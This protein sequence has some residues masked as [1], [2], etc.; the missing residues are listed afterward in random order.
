MKGITPE[1]MAQIKAERK[2]RAAQ[3]AKVWREEL[4]YKDWLFDGHPIRGKVMR[5][6]QR[7]LWKPKNSCCM[8]Q[9][10]RIAH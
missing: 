2:E 5:A 8:V 6:S 4:S 3:V 10:I 7:A 9:Q 1:L